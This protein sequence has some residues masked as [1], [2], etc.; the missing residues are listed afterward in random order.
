MQEYKIIDH[1]E[2]V[3]PHIEDFSNGYTL[4]AVA[5]ETQ[6]G[7]KAYQGLTCVYPV[8]LHVLQGISAWGNKL[9]DNLAF[10]YFPQ[11]EKEK[12]NV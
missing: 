7:W 10:T 2:I 12:Y 9:P 6:M 5:V 3:I 4:V 11:L 8:S 1:K